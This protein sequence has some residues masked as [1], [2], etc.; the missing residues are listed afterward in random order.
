M[1]A[2][3]APASPHFSTLAFAHKNNCVGKNSTPTSIAQ[4]LNV[5]LRQCAA[6]D[7]NSS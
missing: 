5:D 7:F 2:D 4:A 6:M 1:P 3:L